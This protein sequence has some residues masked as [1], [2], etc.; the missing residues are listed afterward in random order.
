MW[1]MPA[2]LDEG[3]EPGHPADSEKHIFM[4]SASPMEPLA[5]D[6]PAYEAYAPPEKSLTSRR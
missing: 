6:L 4:A 1:Y 3:S 2:T 5:R